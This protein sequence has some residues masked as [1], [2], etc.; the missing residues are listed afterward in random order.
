MILYHGTN[1]QFETVNLAASQRGKDFGRGFYLSDNEPQAH[2]IAEFKTLQ[3]GG[4][5]TVHRFEFDKTHLKDGSLKFLQFESYSKEWADFI[6]LNRKNVEEL[7]IHDYDVVFGP[8]ANDKVGV[9]IRNYVEGNIDFDTFLNRLK[10]M[11]G[12]TFQY[13]FNTPRAI[14][15]LQKI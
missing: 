2:D 15:F 1:I 12:I 6:L 9:Q 5:A 11:K 14:A 4:I 10:Y 8:I 7:N 3:L 13:C